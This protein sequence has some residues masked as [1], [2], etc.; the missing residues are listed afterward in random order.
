[1][2]SLVNYSQQQDLLDEE[3]IKLL[4]AAFDDAMEN[5]GVSWQKGLGE[6]MKEVDMT[7]FLSV[8][9]PPKVF[10]HIMSYALETHPY[11]KIPWNASCTNYYQ[12][13]DLGFYKRRL[14]IKYGWMGDED[15]LVDYD[16]ELSD[17]EYDRPY[18]H[19]CGD[20]NHQMMRM[21]C[22]KYVK[23]M[24]ENLN[25]SRTCTRC[26]AFKA[27]LR[28]V[29]PDFKIIRKVLTLDKEP[30][31]ICYDENGENEQ[32]LRYSLTED[33]YADGRRMMLDTKS[34]NGRGA[35]DGRILFRIIAP[36]GYMSLRVMKVSSNYRS[37][38][39]GRPLVDYWVHSHATG[40]ED[41]LVLRRMYQ[42]IGQASYYIFEATNM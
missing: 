41:H 14:Q 2:A 20:I 4:W 23:T 1:M 8:R 33:S 22:N 3:E 35:Y 34:F 36:N 27:Y 18:C 31:R 38:I 5:D 6:F 15:S 29:K 21:S 37:K 40:K 12:P 39:R 9:M 28:N 42:E 26:E 19:Q 7:K 13:I 16:D 30:I 24:Y 17:D 32:F 10:M 25:R 11:T